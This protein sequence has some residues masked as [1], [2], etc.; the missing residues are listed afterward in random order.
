MVAFGALLYANSAMGRKEFRP[1]VLLVITINSEILFESLVSSFCPSPSRWY[2]EVKWSFMSTAFPGDWKNEE[3]NSEPL[4]EIVCEGTPSLEK[5][6]RMNNLA[7]ISA[8]M[9]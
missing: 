9:V 2:L 1:V 4:L 6:W 8:V 3:M 5:T 7:S